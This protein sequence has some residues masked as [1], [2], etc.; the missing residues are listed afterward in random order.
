MRLD[1]SINLLNIFLSWWEQFNILETL[2]TNITRLLEE[3][4]SIRKHILNIIV[5]EHD[6]LLNTNHLC[7]LPSAESISTGFGRPRLRVWAGE[8]NRLY[9]VYRSGK[10]FLFILVFQ[11]E[12]LKEGK[13][14]LTSD[15]TGSCSTYTTILDEPLSSVVRE[16][17]KILPDADETYIIGACH[18]HNIFVLCQRIRHAINTVDPVSRA[19][20]RSISIMRRVYN[21]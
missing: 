17:W 9:D 20:Q 10:K 6:F 15:R 11:S 2:T 12:Y 14:Y 5:T 13:I 1:D 16:V 3:L 8:I 21:V 7:S 4:H 18:Q 19:L